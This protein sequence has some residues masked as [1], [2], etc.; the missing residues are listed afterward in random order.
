MLIHIPTQTKYNNRLEAKKG[1]GGEVKFN[2]AI[3]NREFIF[4]DND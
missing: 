3:K 2:K 4:I 1:L